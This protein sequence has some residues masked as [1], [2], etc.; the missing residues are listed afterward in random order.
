[1]AHKEPT[2]EMILKRTLASTRGECLPKNAAVFS[3]GGMYIP[4]RGNRAKTLHHIINTHKKD[5]PVKV[6][7]G[8]KPRNMLHEAM[9]KESL[10]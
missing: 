4:H 5:E 2:N 6:F 9:I 8:V 1:M 10:N 3:C 7:T